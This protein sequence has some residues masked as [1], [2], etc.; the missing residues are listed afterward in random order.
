[1]KSSLHSLIPFFCH[2]STNRQVLRLSQSPAATANSGTELSS[3]STCVKSS[4]Y[5]IRVDPQKPPI[6][7]LLLVDSLLQ[8][9]VYRTVA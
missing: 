8:K 2:Y 9:C 7:L 5:S 3:I 1:M 6:P 4:L